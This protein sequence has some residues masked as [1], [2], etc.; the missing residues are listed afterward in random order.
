MFVWSDH[1]SSVFPTKKK[2]WEDLLCWFHGPQRELPP[3]HWKIL[4]CRFQLEVLE[5]LFY[6]YLAWILER[7]SKYVCIFCYF[8]LYFCTENTFQKWI[9][10][11]GFSLIKAVYITG[12]EVFSFKMVSFVDATAGSAYTDMNV[13]DVQVTLTVGCIEVV[14][15]TKFLRSILVSILIDF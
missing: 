14:F 1:F 11:V 15:I 13:V 4:Q 12:K 10:I 7:F 8:V 2:C 5:L 3:P 9:L 6:L